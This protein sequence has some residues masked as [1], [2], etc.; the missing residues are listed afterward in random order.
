M[1]EL[2]EVETIRRE[3]EPLLLDRRVKSVEI[4]WPPLVDRPALEDF[5]SRIQGRAIVGL[6]RRGKYLIFDLDSG[7]HW[8]VH[9]RMTGQLYVRDVDSPPDKH[10]HARLFLDNGRVLHYR[11]Q[12][13]FG[14]FYLVT[15]EDDVV[16]HLGPEPLS[17]AWRVEDLAQALTGR[18]ASI[19]ALLLDQ[20]IVAGLGNIY[21]DEALFLAGIHPARAGGDLTQDEVER[22]HIA[23]REVLTEALAARGSTLSTYVPPSERQGSYQ[24][25]RR[26]FRRT[27]A[28]CPLC[29]TPVQRI[30]IVGRS[31]HFCPR[32]QR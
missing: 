17:E 19:K 4:R 32:C 26:V 29:G 11:D 16:G 14:R 27:G 22:L 9:L 15:S 31:T 21:A 18:R 7:E 3:L 28:P 30:K 20:R 24:Q 1:P 10:T 2:P 12:R 25:R 8:I 23:I 13:K 6:R 5:I